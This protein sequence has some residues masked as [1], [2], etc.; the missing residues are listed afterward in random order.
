MINLLFPENIISKEIYTENISEDI[1]P[2]EE[3]FI[4][5]AVEK[6]RLEFMAGRICAKRALS[7]FGITNFPL[8]VAEDKTPIWPSN[9]V[10]SISHTKGYCGIAIAKK[11]NYK[12]IGFDVERIKDVKK[13]TW[14]IICT[15]NEL[16]FIDSLHIPMQQKYASLI[17]SAKECFYKYQYPL[18]KSWLDFHDVEIII[19]PNS[20]EFEIKLLV[21]IDT[22]FSKGNSLKG[23]YLFFEDNVL[24]GMI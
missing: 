2:E 23:K 8:L 24:T 15:K 10:G 17:F 3:V 12:S 1:Y 5:S 6:R 21:D 13:D 20:N 4:R 19:N 18:T 16:L 14:P 9:I 22:H 7:E 11:K